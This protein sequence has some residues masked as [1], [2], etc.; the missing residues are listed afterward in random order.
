MAATDAW[1]LSFGVD[2]AAAIG[3]RELFHILYRPQT[4]VL[5]RTPAH[6]SRVIEWEGQLLPLWDTRGRL[7]E[8]PTTEVAMVAVVGYLDTDGDTAF[9][10]LCIEAPP[11]RITVNDAQA[12]DLPETAPEWRHISQSCFN[13]DDAPVP[14]LDLTSMFTAAARG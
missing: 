7:G 10:A 13:R 9:G 14:I 11:Q 12:C 4:H 5:P 6:C 8:S 1:L 2:C 3:G